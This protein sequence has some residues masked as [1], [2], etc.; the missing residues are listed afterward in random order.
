VN[1]GINHTRE[2]ILDNLEAAR[3]I[4]EAF[5]EGRKFL[6]LHDLANKSGFKRVS[7]RNFKS[8]FNYLVE[9]GVIKLQ[10]SG[11]SSEPRGHGKNHP[12]TVILTADLYEVTDS[13]FQIDHEQGDMELKRIPTF[14]V[15]TDVGQIPVQTPLGH[16]SLISHR[17]FKEWDK[18]K[19]HEGFFWRISKK[20]L[21]LVRKYDQEQNSHNAKVNNKG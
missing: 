20:T 19:N 1:I 2:S 16:E 12:K 7:D 8:G 17:E 13:E 9:K 11:W 14:L 3:Q 15:G 6:C 21:A 5:K 18:S 10:Q 4:L